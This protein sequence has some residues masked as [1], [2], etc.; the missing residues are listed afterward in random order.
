MSEDEK[1]E[2]ATD[3]KNVG[4]ALF[5]AGRI[6]LAME[7]YKKVTS[8]FSYL[9]SIKDEDKKTKAKE[10]KMACELNCAACSLKFKDFAN[11]RE[12]CNKVL[13]EDSRNVKALYRLSQANLGEKNFGDC[14]SNLKK[15][16]EVDPQN[17]D[18][19]ALMKDA[20]AGQKEDDKKSKGMF[21]KMC[22]GLGKGP[23]P[24]PGK[25]KAM[26]ADDY[27]FEDDEGQPAAE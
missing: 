7:R 2:F 24:E 15:L 18:A 1:L 10:L 21:A 17:K 13:K 11:V 23:I 5:K 16:V 25:A 8:L 26:A 14:I 6:Q 27:D 12:S 3:R 22:A 9:D 4:G 19:R 20:K